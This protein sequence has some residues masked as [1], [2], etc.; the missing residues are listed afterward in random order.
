MYVYTCV[1]PE[2]NATPIY[3]RKPQVGGG[4]SVLH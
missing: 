2:E 1:A 3:F 4:E